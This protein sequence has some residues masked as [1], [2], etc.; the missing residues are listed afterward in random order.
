MDE[1]FDDSD[2]S[3]LTQVPQKEVPVFKLLDTSDLE[4][5]DDLVVCDNIQ[6]NIQKNQEIDLED[7]EVVQ[8]KR[9][10]DDVYC[11]DIS[12]DENIDSL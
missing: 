12:S 10:Y 6:K 2:M 11:E 7:G 4:D 8:V 1:S 5:Y 9:L 3:W